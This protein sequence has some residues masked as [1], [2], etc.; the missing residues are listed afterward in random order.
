MTSKPSRP[1][2]RNPKTSLVALQNEFNEA[3]VQEPAQNVLQ[4]LV[5]V[6]IA[7]PELSAFRSVRQ[8]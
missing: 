5:I 8:R 6:E 2:F 7:K 4:L 3:N 1:R